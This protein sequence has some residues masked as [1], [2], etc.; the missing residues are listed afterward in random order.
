MIDAQGPSVKD[1]LAKLQNDQD[2]LLELL[3]DQEQKIA[4]FK[5]RLKELGEEVTNF[6][7]NILKYC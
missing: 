4:G 1:E 2:D 5:K 6:N 7:Y 3:A